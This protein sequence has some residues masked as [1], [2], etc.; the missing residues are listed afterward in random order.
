[1]M[2]HVGEIYHAKPQTDLQNKYNKY[3]R[4]AFQNRIA[5]TGYYMK[6]VTI[7][8]QEISRDHKL[9]DSDNH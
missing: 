3:R 2:V 9:S 5:A 8:T 4:L 1:M 7:P 6:Y